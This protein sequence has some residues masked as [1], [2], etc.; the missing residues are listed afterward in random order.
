MK[1]KESELTSYRLQMGVIKGL[2]HLSHYSGTV[3]ERIRWHGGCQWWWWWWC[4]VQKS[5]TTPCKRTEFNCVSSRMLLDPVKPI[6][7][8]CDNWVATSATSTIVMTTS[9]L[10]LL[11]THEDDSHKPLLLSETRGADLNNPLISNTSHEKSQVI[12][13]LVGLFS[14]LWTKSMS[15]VMWKPRNSVL[16]QCCSIHRV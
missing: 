4:W 8:G 16:L 12:N 15:A 6:L 7:W 3:G 13:T 11:H 14:T 10:F 2:S 1:W 9:A 5:N